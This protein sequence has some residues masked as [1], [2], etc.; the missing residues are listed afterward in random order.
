MSCDACDGLELVRRPYNGRGIMNSVGQFRISRKFRQ[1]CNKWTA[2][3][4]RWT[5][6]AREGRRCLRA[7]HTQAVCEDPVQNG[8]AAGEQHQIKC[9]Q[10]CADARSAVTF[11]DCCPLHLPSR[12]QRISQPHTHHMRS[13]RG[14]FRPVCRR[15]GGAPADAAAHRHGR[16]RWLSGHFHWLQVRFGARQR[17]PSPCPA[18]LSHTADPRC[19][20][21]HPH[22]RL[23]A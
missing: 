18:R 20:R 10:V 3:T 8:R 19:Q 1:R 23:L 15:S 6:A 9:C 16:P 11:A 7:C 4:L 17:L 2:P 5:A 21:A 13:Q 22:D 14:C 12:A